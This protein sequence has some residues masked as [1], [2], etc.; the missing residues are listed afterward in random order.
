[1]NKKKKKTVY[2]YGLK[3]PIIGKDLLQKMIESESI[4]ELEPMV[5]EYA[6][7][8][9]EAN[10]LPKP[11]N[12]TTAK[13]LFLRIFAK[14]VQYT[15]DSAIYALYTDEI[16]QKNKEKLYADNIDTLL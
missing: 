4:V 1:M 2:F 7:K 3:I 16:S 9:A 6:K 12:Y 13:Y 14:A 11:F 5:I 10:K 8:L 15:L